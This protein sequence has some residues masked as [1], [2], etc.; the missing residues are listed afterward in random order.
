MQNYKTTKLE[1]K[2][3]IVVIYLKN[4]EWSQTPIEKRAKQLIYKK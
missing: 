4:I 1:R 2:K 3:E